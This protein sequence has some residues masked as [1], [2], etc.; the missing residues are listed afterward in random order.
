MRLRGRAVAAATV[1]LLGVAYCFVMYWWQLRY[2]YASHGVGLNFFMA[3][4]FLG[5]A[6]IAYGGMSRVATILGWLILAVMTG[7]AY[8]GAATSS[9]S[10]APVLYI[11]P[12]FYGA[13]VLSILFAID[14]I[15]RHRRRPRAASSA[16]SPG[17]AGTPPR[18]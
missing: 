16:T 14:D 9:S 18:R 12:L 2:E 17:S 10:T 3:L 5:L 8:V 7:T 4:P 13:I 11:A 1:L 15:V 6:V